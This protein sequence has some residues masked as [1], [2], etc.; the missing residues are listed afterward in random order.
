M[1]TL[2]TLR[3]LVRINIG[4]REDADAVAIMNAAI[5]YATL[6]AS[7]VFEPPELRTY[8][9]T[10][11]GAGSSTIS[12]SVLTRPLDLISLYNETDDKLMGFIP[13]EIFSLVVPAAAPA[14]SFYTVFGESILV[15]STPSVNKS[16]KIYYSQY[17]QELIEDTDE[18]DFEHHDSYIV[19]VASGICMAAFEE[20][21]SAQMWQN[22]AQYVTTPFVLGARARSL[23]AGRAVELEKAMAKREE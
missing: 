15:K 20:V 17:P 9:T 14:A 1:T 4:G 3:E 12:F 13:F 6:L 21:E 2:A 22:V 7:I 8:T 19:S 23:I 11:L 16:I 18:L 10:Q 5:N